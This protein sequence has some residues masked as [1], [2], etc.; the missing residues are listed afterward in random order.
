MKENE[1]ITDPDEI[2]R[3]AKEIYEEKMEEMRSKKGN[4]SNG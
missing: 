4:S 2:R 1:L 3:I